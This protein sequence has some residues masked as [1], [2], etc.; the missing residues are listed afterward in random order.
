M[1]RA[2]VGVTT[3]VVVELCRSLECPIHI[4]WNNCKIEGCTPQRT[5]YETVCFEVRGDHAYFI[6]DPNTKQHIAK[7]RLTEPVP[8]NLSLIHI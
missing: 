6:G 3:A 2:E 4:V 8:Q 5:A 7:S 1:S